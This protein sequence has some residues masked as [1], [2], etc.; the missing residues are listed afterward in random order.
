[1]SDL[2]AIQRRADAATE[3]PWKSEPYRGPHE[4]VRVTS[5]VDCG[6]HNL[7]E[8]V[9]PHDA[10]FIANARTDIP[11]LLALVR[12]Q[13]ARLAVVAELANWAGKHGWK[14]DAA[15]IRAALEPTE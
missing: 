11:T 4:F 2:D 12:S 1:M 14:L 3:G 7:A 9:R 5:P 6:I 8:D 15:A 13:Q 10:E